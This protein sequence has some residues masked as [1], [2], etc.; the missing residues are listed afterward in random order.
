MLYQSLNYHYLQKHSTLFHYG[1]YFTLFQVMMVIH[2]TSYY[3]EAFQCSY[4]MNYINVKL[5]KIE[6]RVK[7]FNKS[8]N[9]IKNNINNIIYKKIRNFMISF[10]NA[11]LQILIST[12]IM[13]WFYQ[14]IKKRITNSLER[15]NKKNQLFLIDN[16]IQVVIIKN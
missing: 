2:I 16:K 10:K 8:L 7:I 3:Q 11:N 6:Y 12:I 9:K 5:K 1:K 15:L 14:K 4:Q 13:I